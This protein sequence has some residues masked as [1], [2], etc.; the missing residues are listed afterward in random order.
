MYYKCIVNDGGGGQEHL[1][2]PERK[3]D[4]SNDIGNNGWNGVLNA[5]CEIMCSHCS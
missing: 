1:G 5:G 2:I 3:K 4:V